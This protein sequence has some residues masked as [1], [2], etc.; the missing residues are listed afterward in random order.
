VLTIS[1]HAKVISTLLVPLKQPGAFM[2][3]DERVMAIYQYG[4]DG[5]VQ[6]TYCG[7]IDD[8]SAPLNDTTS[9]RSLLWTAYTRV[10]SSNTSDITDI[11]YLARED[12]LIQYI[13]CSKYR[14]TIQPRMGD[15]AKV[16]IGVDTAFATLKLEFSTTEGLSS[17]EY[18]LI[19]GSG[20]NGA[21]YEVR[22]PENVILWMR[23]I[24]LRLILMSTC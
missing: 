10:L 15:A 17:H 12:G 20:G 22:K 23:L 11:F 21:I 19:S 24:V 2:I 16:S 14:D 13:E 4:H 6:Q 5:S 8:E 3:F 7:G 9:A 18:L 1:E